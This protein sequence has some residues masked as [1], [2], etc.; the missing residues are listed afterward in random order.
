MISISVTS[1]NGG[2]T[3]PLVRPLRRDRRQHRPGREQ[4]ARPARPGAHDLAGPCPGRV[5]QRPLRDHRSRQQSDLG[6]RPAARQRPGDVHPARRRA[7]DRRLRDAGRGGCAGRRRGRRRPVRR[8]SRPG[9]DTT[10]RRAR[11]GGGRTLRGSARGLRRRAARSSGAA[12]RAAAAYAPPPSSPAPSAGG[13]PQD[14]DPFAPDPKTIAPQGQDFARSL[15]QPGA[16]AAAI[17]ASM[18]AAAPSP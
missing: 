1:F 15:G 12:S 17:S 3:A 14:W 4:P 11:A 5:P 10:G 8:L 9:I 18:S 6:Q 2:A 16:A 13:I 7:A